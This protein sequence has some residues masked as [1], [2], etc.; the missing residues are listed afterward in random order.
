MP[1]L[2]DQANFSELAQALHEYK[3]YR[4][5]H[6]HRCDS[7]PPDRTVVDADLKNWP[8]KDFHSRNWYLG[9]DEYCNDRGL[10]C[11]TIRFNFCP[12]CGE[13]LK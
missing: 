6:E 13:G 1:A 5:Y 8:D 3:Y 12:F 11:I 2:R 10:P 4:V 9:E 7:M